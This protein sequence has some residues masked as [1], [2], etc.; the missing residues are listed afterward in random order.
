MGINREARRKELFSLLGDLP[1]RS[2]KISVSRTSSEDRGFYV[3]EKLMLDLNGIEPVPAYF[4]RPRMQEGRMP[5]L[6]YNHAHGGDYALGKDELILGRSG[7]Q[8]PAYAEELARI[9]YSALCI[10]A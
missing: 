10:D 5:T 9:G 6:L 4:S 1:D 8:K 7:L 2:R 3:L